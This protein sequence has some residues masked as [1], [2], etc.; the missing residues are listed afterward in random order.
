MNASAYGVTS[1]TS[2]GETPAC[3]QTTTLRTVFPPEPDVVMPA[4]A[5]RA[6][7]G[8]RSAGRTKLSWKFWRVVTCPKP[9][10]KRTATSAR[11]RSCSAETA[12]CGS[13]M[14]SMCT[15]SWRCACAPRATR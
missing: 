1:K 3:G 8:S 6:I 4:S 11:A 2:S 10:E 5:R 14:R 9:R 12:P 15:P 13:L 7:A